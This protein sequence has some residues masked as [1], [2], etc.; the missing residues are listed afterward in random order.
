MHDAAAATEVV[1]DASGKLVANAMHCQTTRRQPPKGY[2][3]QPL[4]CAVV[5]CVGNR[6]KETRVA[7]SGILGTIGFSF[8]CIWLAER[9]FRLQRQATSKVSIDIFVRFPLASSAGR[10]VHTPGSL[11]TQPPHFAEKVVYQL[12]RVLEFRPHALR[13]VSRKGPNHKHS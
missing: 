1:C 12:A 6:R 11:K 10:S 9:V 3:D 4:C 2:A 8:S 7:S 5:V 13:I